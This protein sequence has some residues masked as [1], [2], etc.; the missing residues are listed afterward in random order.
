MARGPE[1][2]L[3]GKIGR[4]ITK[5]WPTAWAIK[6]Q[7]GPYQTAGVPDLLVVVEGLLV[8]I[9]VK[10]RRN[11]ESREHAFGRVTL[12][13][14]G[15]IEALRRAGAFAG[16]ALSVEESMAIVSHRLGL[17]DSSNADLTRDNLRR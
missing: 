1:T 6:I 10:A 4:A 13:Q 5:A 12:R 9:E 16:P 3:V 8:G 2:L 11:G 15:T 7:G 14:W 17:L